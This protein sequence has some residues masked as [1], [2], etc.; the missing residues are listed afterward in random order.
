MPRSGAS[1]DPGSSSR[2]LPGEHAR[3]PPA[4]VFTKNIASCDFFL[5][6]LC[7]LVL[8]RPSGPSA[9][10]TRSP[11]RKPGDTGSLG[12]PGSAWH[13]GW[14]SCPE[15]PGFRRGLLLPHTSPERQRRDHPPPSPYWPR[16]ESNPHGDHSPR[17]FK[18]RASAC[19]ATRPSPP[20]RV[21]GGPA[22]VEADGSPIVSPPEQPLQIAG[23]G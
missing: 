8:T 2:R 19:F 1:R 3:S 20:E 5:A 12:V 22:G 14:C 10:L 11:G 18:S 4:S 7:P 23:G 6:G 16:R 17:D 9:R 15:S 13:V 21:T